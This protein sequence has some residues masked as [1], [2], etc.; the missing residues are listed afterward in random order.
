MSPKQAASIARDFDQSLTAIAGYSDYLLNRLD[1]SDPLFRE[2]TQLRQSAQGVVPLT[3]QL[4]AISRRESFRSGEVDLA[5]VIG[6][7]E[8]QFPRL[9][10]DVHVYW[11]TLGTARNRMQ[12][13][14]IRGLAV[15]AP[16]RTSILPDLPTFKELGYP[17][18]DAS[19][20]Q[21]CASSICPRPR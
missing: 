1:P 16:E 13:Q 7:L 9:A 8:P 19:S 6:E 21:A 2:V 4:L 12:N 20:W 17:G 11:D 3:R 14:Q 18:M 15:T 5:S 10:G